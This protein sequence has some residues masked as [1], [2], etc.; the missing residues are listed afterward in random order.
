MFLL[1]VYLVSWNKKPFKEPVSISVSIPTDNHDI[2]NLNSTVQNIIFCFAF[3]IT[4]R[5]PYIQEN[6]FHTNVLLKKEFLDDVYAIILDNCILHMGMTSFRDL[7][8]DILCTACTD[9][10][11]KNNAL[12]V[13]EMIK[14]E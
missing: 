1:V 4:S 8:N 2:T 5:F 6:N 7:K 9:H 13:E 3:E 14:T 12:D 11:N 10:C